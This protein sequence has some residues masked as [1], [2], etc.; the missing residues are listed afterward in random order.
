M[1]RIQPL[2]DIIDNDEEVRNASYQGWLIW[3]VIR[4]QVYQHIINVENG[5]TSARKGLKFPSNQILKGF[6][7]ALVMFPRLRKVNTLFFSTTLSLIKVG[8]AGYFNRVSDYFIPLLSGN[9]AV[10]EESIDYKHP[11]PRLG[12]AAVFSKTIATLITQIIV[13]LQL[14]FKT[15]DAIGAYIEVD[16]L[17]ACVSELLREQNRTIAADSLYTLRKALVKRLISIKPT[18]FFYTKLLRNSSVR[19]IV[20]EDGHYGAEKSII[21]FCAHKLGIKVYEPQHGFLNQNHPAYYFGSL[22]TKDEAVKRY[23][24]DTLFTYGPYWSSVARIP[25]Q[26]IEIGNP[27]FEQT[28]ERNKYTKE[29]CILVIGSGVTVSETNLVLKKLLQLAE[30]YNILYRPHP[31]EKNTHSDRYK[32]VYNDGV[33]QDTAPLY[34]SLAKAEIVIAEVSTVLFEAIAFCNFVYLLNTNYTK[35]CYDENLKYFKLIEIDELEVVLDKC[36]LD[37]EAAMQ[38]YWTFDWKRKFLQY[39]N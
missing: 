33:L 31:Q 11:M 2:I 23:Y 6:F 16:K 35:S 20:M 13:E 24:P 38:Y 28:I 1:S 36:G 26:K 19:V 18:A 22:F 4:F 10:I 17:L 37:R 39:L 5:L 9:C 34:E 21:N 15:K 25:N 27:H 14:V 29:K 7:P 30:G 3:P 8:N 12:K 32:E